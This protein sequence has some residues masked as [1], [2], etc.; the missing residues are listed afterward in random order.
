MPASFQGQAAIPIVA[1]ISPNQSALAAGAEIFFGI[2]LP[3]PLVLPAAVAAGPSVFALAQ[4]IQNDTANASL[5]ATC[6]LNGGGGN[7]YQVRVRNV[8]SA[9]SGTFVVAVLIFGPGQAIGI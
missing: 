3:S 7:S 2:T 5:V 8:G 6:N 1:V 4:V 9:T